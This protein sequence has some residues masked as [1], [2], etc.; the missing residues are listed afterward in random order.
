MYLSP[1][2]S[3]AA[4]QHAL[5]AYPNESCGL[6][7]NDVYFSCVNH[8]QD[9]V[10]NFRIDP[11]TWLKAQEQG[12]IR[13]VLHSHPDGPH[14][15]TKR[16]MQG[17]IDS[18]VP[19]GVIWTDGERTSE[20]ILWGDTLPIQPLV[21]RPFVHGV[22]DCYS[23]VR[24]AFRLGK[25][26]MAYQGVKEWPFEPV[27]MP[28]VP[29]DDSWWT[30]DEDLYVDHLKSVGWKEIAASDV[31]P[32]DGFLMKIRSSKMNHAGLYVGNNLILHHLPTRVSRRE[33]VGIWTRNVDMWLRYE[34]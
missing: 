1:A 15:P 6:V 32:G 16:D 12:T 14:N 23:L 4:R 7:V 10:N 34:G 20:P 11:R 31:Q 13:A 9:P 3:T 21:G 24:D 30:T 28:E 25:E 27:T 26:Q 17:Q 22:T 5:N 19:W 29:R 8:A 18:A 2:V 33:P